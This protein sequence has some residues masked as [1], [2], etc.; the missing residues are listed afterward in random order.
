VYGALLARAYG[1]LATPPL[2]TG[3]SGRTCTLI[4][5]AYMSGRA[6]GRR[7][8]R[9]FVRD[10]AR[11]CGEQS[12]FTA[13]AAPFRATTTTT[14]P[15]WRPAERPPRHSPAMRRG[16][17]DRGVA[18]V[19]IRQHVPVPCVAGGLYSSAAG[20]GHSVPVPVPPGRLE[21]TAG[22]R[23]DGC[24][25]RGARGRFVAVSTCVAAPSSDRGSWHDTYGDVHACCLSIDLSSRV[26][27]CVASCLLSE[28]GP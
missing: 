9:A 15:W 14:A 4:D 22:G 21:W 10:R 26:G 5:R 20:G 27:F 16:H 7:S 13:P 8:G 18:H 24:A 17:G 1:T 12:P 25:P 2:T 28:S 19:A 11:L 6:D 3:T 23:K